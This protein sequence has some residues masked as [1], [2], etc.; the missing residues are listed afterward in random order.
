[1]YLKKNISFMV[2]FLSLMFPQCRL[3]V[4]TY[5]TSV[6]NEPVL[7]SYSGVQLRS[8]RFKGER[9]VVADQVSNGGFLMQLH[10]KNKIN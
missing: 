10:L 1:M 6:N 7:V 3:F 9:F 2:L 4:C 8:C 5:W